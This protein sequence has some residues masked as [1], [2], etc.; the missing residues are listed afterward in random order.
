MKVAVLIDTWFPTIGGGQ[1]TAWEISR[2][3]AIKGI[4]VD[5]ITRD[6][7]ILKKSPTKGL[8]V[9]K[10]LKGKPE[11]NFSRMFYLVKSFFYVA[12]NDY[13]LVHA[14]AFLPG[15]TAF[16]LKIFKKIPVI[17]HV[18]GTALGTN[19]KGPLSNFLEKVLLTKI[20]YTAEITVSRDFLAIENINKKVYYLPN[21]VNVKDFD[22]VKTKKFREKTLLFVGRL[23]PQKNVLTLIKAFSIFLKEK[24]NFKL[25]LIGS[26]PQ[27]KL[28]REKI[29]ELQIQKDVEVVG[30]LDNMAV[31]EY[32]KRSHI[33]ILTSIYEGFPL[34]MLEAWAA[35]IPIIVP[36]TGDCQFIVKDGEN[37]FLI[38]EI[39]DP[40]IIA[41]ILEKAIRFKNLE[42]LGRNGY[43]LVKENY[44]WEKAAQKTKNIYEEII[45]ANKRSNVRS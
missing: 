25:V 8:K 44:T 45:S 34:A 1:I 2:R 12:K 33:F 9:V 31:I 13:D 30:E 23:H 7:G 10:L 39:L 27:Q 6:C 16:F 15:F 4:K 37:G 38:P 26:G 22:K 29:K 35:K 17:C 11:D 3:L 20:P 19:L 41:K 43:N 36:K 21:G 18:H 42:K 40:N 28:V 5:I 24:K 14:H 32:F